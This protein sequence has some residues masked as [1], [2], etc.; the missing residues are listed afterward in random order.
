MNTVCQTCKKYFIASIKEAA[1]RMIEQA[2]AICEDVDV[3]HVS[4]IDICV[5]LRCDSV[6]EM[7]I[8][9]TYPLGVGV[10]YN[11]EK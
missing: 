5:N 7:Q 8:E 9:K 1:E 2:E 6:S 4:G 10:M 11:E 3:N